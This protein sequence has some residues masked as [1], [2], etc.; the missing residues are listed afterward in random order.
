VLAEL[1]QQYNLANAI[2]MH[3][4]RVIDRATLS[5]IVAGGVTL[6]LSTLAGTTTFIQIRGSAGALRCVRQRGYSSGTTTRTLPAEIIVPC[7]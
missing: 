6:D 1:V 5:A 2:M 3:L 4:T 7:K